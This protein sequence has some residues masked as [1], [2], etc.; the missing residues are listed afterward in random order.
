MQKAEIRQI[1]AFFVM[2][3]LQSGSL[4][5]VAAWFIKAVQYMAGQSSPTIP[6]PLAGEERD[7][8]TS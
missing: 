6:S 4:D 3:I 7:L 1:V 2:R 5:Y 8:A